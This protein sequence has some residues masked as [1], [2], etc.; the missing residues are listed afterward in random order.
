MQIICSIV[1]MV[2]YGSEFNCHTLYTVTQNGNCFSFPLKIVQ[3]ILNKTNTVKF[4]K[5]NYIRSN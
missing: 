2:I 4:D 5:M 3:Y 1:N